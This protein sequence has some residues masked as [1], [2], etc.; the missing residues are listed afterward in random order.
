VDARSACRL[1]VVGDEQIHLDPTA[2]SNVIRQK[3][4]I[5]SQH[6]FDDWIEP[7]S[8]YA[9]PAAEFHRKDS[10][11]IAVEDW[12]C[13]CGEELPKG[14]A[15]KQEQCCSGQFPACQNILG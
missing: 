12:R 10:E 3:I 8:R 7:W 9:L 4:L 11:C 15:D 6:L 5:G 2:S 1:V 13:P 14:A